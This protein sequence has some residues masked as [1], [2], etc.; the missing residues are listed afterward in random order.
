[1]DENTITFIAP[2]QGHEIKRFITP[3]LILRQ[4][5]YQRSGHLWHGF[6]TGWYGNL[7]NNQRFIPLF[8]SAER[9]LEV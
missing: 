7:I 9:G 8:A 5:I 2:V 1:M 4:D 6:M 3:A